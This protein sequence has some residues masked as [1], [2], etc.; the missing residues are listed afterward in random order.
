MTGAWQGACA[1]PGLSCYNGLM[2]TLDR[3]SIVDQL[4]DPVSQMLTPEVAKKLV[5]LRFGAKTQARLDR[6]ARRCNEGQLSDQER[7]DYES[8][9]NAID[10]IAILQAKARA[11]L[12][13]LA[14]T[15]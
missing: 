9:V 2:E 4:L 7:K 6:L 11:R 1:S 13:R 3:P 5:R 15:D 8:Y 14:E 10:F 12:R